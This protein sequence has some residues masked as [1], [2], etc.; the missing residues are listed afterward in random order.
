MYLLEYFDKEHR[1]AVLAIVATAVCVLSLV[2]SLA[3]Y[4]VA[5]VIVR[6]ESVPLGLPE[7]CLKCGQDPREARVR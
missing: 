7:K 5:C 2:T 1:L 6:P 4:N 3:A